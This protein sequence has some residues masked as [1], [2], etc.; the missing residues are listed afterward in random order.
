MCVYN[1]FCTFIG[2]YLSS[3]FTTCTLSDM[4][5]P[6]SLQHE[7]AD[8]WSEHI[9]SSGKKYYYNCRTEVSQWEKPKDW[10]ERWSKDSPSLLFI[11]VFFASSSSV[12]RGW[13]SSGTLYVPLPP[14]LACEG[15]DLSITQGK[16]CVTVLHAVLWAGQLISLCRGFCQCAQ[17]T[18]C[19]VAMMLIMNCCPL[20]RGVTVGSKGRKRHLNQHPR[21]TVFPKTGTTDEKPCR[22]QPPALSPVPVRATPTF[23]K[24]PSQFQQCLRAT[25][26]RAQVLFE[27]LT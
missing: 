24:W 16:C 17:C 25:R 2:L 26:P 18:V 14:Y 11:L 19:S 9:S 22:P 27:G 6:P 10:V 13:R 12:P 21:S 5:S 3:Y 4:L 8:D 7:P 23:T 20:C 15:C 1:H